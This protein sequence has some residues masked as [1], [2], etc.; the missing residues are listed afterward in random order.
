MYKIKNLRFGFVNKSCQVFKNLLRLFPSFGGVRGGFWG[1]RG[2]VLGLLFLTVFTT[3]AQVK[4]GGTAGN[5]DLSAHLQIGDNPAN[6]GLLLP[7]VA[8]TATGTFGLTGASQ[9]AGMFVYNTATNSSTAGEEVTPGTYYW[10]GTKWMRL[11]DVPASPSSSGGTVTNF[12]A[13]NLTPLFTTNVTNATTIPDLSFNLS[14]AAATTVFGNNTGATAAPIYFPSANLAIDGDVKG[15]LGASV[16]TQLQGTPVSTATPAGGEVLTF[17]NVNGKWTPAFLPAA[18]INATPPIT[19]NTAG[20][21]TTI[22]VNSGSITINGTASSTVAAASPL[23]ATGALANR[24]LATGNLD[25]SVNNAAP[26]WNANQLYGYEVA[27]TIP[28]ANQVLTYNGLA[29][30]P[31]TPTTNANEWHLGG[32]SVTTATNLGTI[33]N[34]DLPVIT[35]N[36]Q[37]MVIKAAGNVGIGTN[38]PA[39][40]LEVNGASTNTNATNAT[41]TTVNFALSNLAY[42]SGAGNNPAFTIQNTKSGGTYTLSWQG[43]GTGIATFTAIAGFTIKVADTTVSKTSTQHIVYTIVCINTTIYVYPTLF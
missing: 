29:W 26:L 33:T 8:L 39:T 28:S 38:T 9:T 37:R 16:V 30:T 25:F 6:K 10:N 43:T 32:N 14:N 2:L 1:V 20:T 4:I 12:S 23:T 18:N 24:L 13:G 41:T 36:T 42:Y 31:I 7:R 35:N 19:A 22:G 17:D 34:F 27:N 15:T 5:T 11:I 21:V 3:H 40:V